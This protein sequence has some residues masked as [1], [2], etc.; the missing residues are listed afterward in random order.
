MK[1]PKLETGMFGE[2]N[3][4]SVFVVV[5]DLIVYQNGGFDEV[6]NFDNDYFGVED[7]NYYITK[8]AKNVGSFNHYKSLSNNF[9]FDRTKPTKKM[10]IDEIEEAL[11]YKIEIVEPCYPFT[12][13]N[14]N[15]VDNY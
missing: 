2:M 5:N 3:D 9:I 14:N 11:G 10:T 1:H 12:D 13:T 8:L 15:P 6:S 4:G 7:L